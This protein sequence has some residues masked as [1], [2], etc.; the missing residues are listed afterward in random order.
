MGKNFWKLSGIRKKLI[1][2]YL[3]ITILMGTTSFYSYYSA[4]LVISRLNSIFIDYVYLNNLYSDLSSLETSVEKYLSTKSSEALL[5]YYTL[6]NKLQNQAVEL[7]RSISYDK[8][9]LMLKD[10]GNMMKSLLS[11]TDAA[12][13]AKRGRISSEYLAHFTESNKIA[14]FIKLYINDLL[15]NKLQEG[16]QKYYAIKGNMAIVSFLNVFLILGALVLNIFLAMYFTYKITRPII[17]LSRSAERISRGDFDMEPVKIQTNDEVNVLADAFNRMAVSIKNY[18]DK[19][20]QQAEVEKK[21]QE[22][23]V[24]N[25]RM[26]GI[27]KDAELKAL[28]SQINPHFLFNTLNAASQLALMEGAEQSSVFIENVANLFRYNLRRLDKPVTLRDEIDNVRT[29]M[30]ILKTRFGDK[31]EFSVDVR[32]ELLD[33]E[34]PCTVIQPVV[35]N[36]FIHGIE[37]LER[38]GKIMI[39]V[40]K[41]D[42]YVAVEVSDDGLGMDETT[43][44]SILAVETPDS[45]TDA[46]LSGIGMHNVI[47]RLMLFYNADKV[48]DVIEIFSR[49]GEGTQVI[50]KMPLA[51]GGVSYA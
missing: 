5:D 26:K 25:L 29:Y 3:I 12:V 45:I 21:L 23:E 46:H 36:A 40:R 2:Y 43:I 17:E 39:S 35:E 50:L 32:E 34:V 22:Q 11:E 6:S 51:K 30:Y 4:R 18:I 49:K 44:N 9:G 47:Y 15:Y 8:N 1:V 19:I 33:I 10:I 37:G 41:T 24:Q 20:K 28:Q 14:G 38:P 31:V 16:S 27:L 7:S 42:N 13:N 48:S